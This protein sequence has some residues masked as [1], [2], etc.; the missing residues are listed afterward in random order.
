MKQLCLAA[1]F[2]LAICNAGQ[3]QNLNGDWQGTLKIGSAELRLVLHVSGSNGS[4]T[5]TLDS[6]DQPGGNGIAVTAFSLKPPQ[7]HFAADSVHGSYSGDVN[8]EGTLMHGTW[9]QGPSWPLD[10]KRAATPV[11]TEH[12]LAARSDIDGDWHGTLDAGGKKLRLV[13]HIV[14]MDDGLSATLDSLDQHAN[15]IPVTSVTRDGDSLILQLK[16]INGSFTGKISGDRAAIEGTWTQAGG[17][18]PLA[19]TRSVQ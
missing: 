11:K 7:V 5:A 12:H 3:A 18:L 15:G 6:I 13:F 9:T 4:Y 10:F 16:Q 14:N 17:S 2:L 8:I 19:L 1:V